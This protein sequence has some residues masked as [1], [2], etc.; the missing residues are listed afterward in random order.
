M[1]AGQKGAKR[2]RE[3]DRKSKRKRQTKLF[4]CDPNNTNPTT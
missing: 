1:K 3:K 2:N 4:T